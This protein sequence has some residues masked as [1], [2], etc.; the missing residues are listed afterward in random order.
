M[1]TCM[2]FWKNVGSSTVRVGMIRIRFVMCGS[3]KVR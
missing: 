2:G 3:K 1:G